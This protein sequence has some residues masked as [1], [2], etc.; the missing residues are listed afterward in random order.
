[1]FQD[2]SL[3]DEKTR[4]VAKQTTDNPVTE[5]IYW[6][7]VNLD[8]SSVGVFTNGHFTTL[9]DFSNTLKQTIQDLGILDEKGLVSNFSFFISGEKK[10]EVFLAGVMA[11]SADQQA[12][13]V[14]RFSVNVVEVDENLYRL[15]WQ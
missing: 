2:E 7:R 1:M 14:E 6:I 13:I 10:R 3:S 11:L 4:M 5:L 8:D 12:M 15:D 9:E